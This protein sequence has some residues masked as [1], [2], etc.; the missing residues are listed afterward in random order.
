[1]TVAN[2]LHLFPITTQIA[3]TSS[4]ECLTISGLNLLELAE[5]FGTPLYL[6]DA[7]TLDS[8]VAIYQSALRKYYPGKTGITYA[9]KAFLNVAQAQW[10]QRHNLWVDCTGL[11]EL[12]I[13]SAAGVPREHI[14]IH[15]VNKSHAAL[16]AGIARSGTIVVD[17]LIELERL[18][19]LTSQAAHPLPN[20]WLRF[21]PG[22]VVET[23]SHI[24]TGQHDSKFGMSAREIV[25]A[26]HI[27]RT[28]KLPLTGLHFH[29]GSQ[30]RNPEPIEYA[31]EHTLAL[32]QELRLEPGWTLCVGGGWGISYHED[33]LPH[34]N[35]EAYTRFVAEKVVNICK[36]SG[37]PIP[38]LRLEPGRSLVARAGVALYR[39]G[40]V[41]HTP[42]RRWLLLD[43]G[44]ADNPRFALY[45]ARY[46]ALPV[47]DPNRPN[48]GPAWLGGPFCES[49]DVLIE[50]LPFPDVQPDELIA[51]PVSGAYQLS[52]ASNYNG[53]ARPAVV[54]L[55][56]D[57]AKLIRKRETPEDLIRYDNP[58]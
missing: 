17:N 47:L 22:K 50:N 56:N 45:Q 54:W 46:S 28:Q 49:G 31:L 13:A 14:L 8:A 34:P 58:L 52:M 42:K 33:D 2:K 11:G 38:R 5:Q 23:H 41:K 25:E 53:A 37:I 7:A 21:R 18:A 4:G 27:C 43:G 40:T 3:A 29:L 15:G 51:I 12:H 57:Q 30:F 16:A 44:L 9:G 6:Y 48:S 36:E 19:K 10:T 55:E 1:M 39:V 32:A 26:A 24:Q 20:L 35:A